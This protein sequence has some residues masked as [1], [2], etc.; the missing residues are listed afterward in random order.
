MN[1]KIAHF[2]R[3]EGKLKEAKQIPDSA[4]YLATK[5]D[6]NLELIYANRALIYILAS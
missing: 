2:L 6:L 5:F 1:T 4:F 3:D